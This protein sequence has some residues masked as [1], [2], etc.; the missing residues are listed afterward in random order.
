MALEA[1]FEYLKRTS[2]FNGGP[3]I[4]D[5]PPQS[6]KKMSKEAVVNNLKSIFSKMGKAQAD[7]DG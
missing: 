2:V 1:R 7:G 4:D 3:H 6:G 5:K